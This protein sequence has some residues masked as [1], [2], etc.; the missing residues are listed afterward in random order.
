MLFSF[1]EIANRLDM[2]G[3]MTE[4]EIMKEFSKADLCGLY[5]PAEFGGFGG[6]RQLH[7]TVMSLQAQAAGPQRGVVSSAD[8]CADAGAPARVRARDPQNLAKGRARRR[9]V[10]PSVRELRLHEGT[11]RSG[12]DRA[13]AYGVVMGF[14]RLLAKELGAYGITVNSISPSTILTQRIIKLRDAES[15]KKIADVEIAAAADGHL[16]IDFVTDGLQ[17]KFGPD[18]VVD[19]PLAE[20]GIV[21]WRS[22]W[23]FMEFVR[24]QKFNLKG[25]SIPAS[26][27]STITSDEFEPGQGEDSRAPWS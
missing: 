24:L 25:S 5:I 8:P 26:I 27:R 4:E 7:A 14:T 19:T 3:I 18:R 1:I 6:G 13:L 15:L 17:E 22:A 10:N 23:R 21:G 2:S 16:R 9:L 11:W 20:L 12:P